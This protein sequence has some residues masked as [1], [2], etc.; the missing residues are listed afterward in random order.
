[1]V[2]HLLFALSM[3]WL[4]TW[5]DVANAQGMDCDNRFNIDSNFNKFNKYF[6]EGLGI[7]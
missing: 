6:L 2:K 7:N 4:M 1:M 3:L 5:C